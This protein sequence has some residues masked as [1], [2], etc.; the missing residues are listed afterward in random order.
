VLTPEEVVLLRTV[1]RVFLQNAPIDGEQATHLGHSIER[2]I[3]DRPYPGAN[4]AFVSPP[5]EEDL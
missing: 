2:I 4:T 3:G 1:S 5:K